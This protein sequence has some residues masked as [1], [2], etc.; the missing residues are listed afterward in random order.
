MLTL[1]DDTDDLLTAWAYEQ[2][3]RDGF[4][5]ATMYGPNPLIPPSAEGLSIPPG[6]PRPPVPHTRYGHTSIKTAPGPRDWEPR[7]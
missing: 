4:R 6:T 2:G 3:L 1:W 7:L 5:A